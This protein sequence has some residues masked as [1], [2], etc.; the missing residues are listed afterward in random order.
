MSSL[1]YI[2]G[3][4]VLL[5]ASREDLKSKKVNALVLLAASI[6]ILLIR[7]I[8]GFSIKEGLIGTLLG[9]GMLLLSKASRGAVGLG[10]GIAL[11][12]AGSCTSFRFCLSVL[13]ISLLLMFIISAV[14]MAL[15]RLKRQD[16]LAYVP[17]LTAA[18]FIG[19]FLCWL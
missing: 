14:L 4:A 16:S 19:G 17:W 6:C 13:M 3:G 10:D 15:K 5:N 11:I 18:Y 1:L 8:S 7:G 9:I 2:I 12:L